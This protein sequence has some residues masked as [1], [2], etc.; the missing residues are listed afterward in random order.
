M[1]HSVC[2]PADAY[3]WKM[4]R[5]ECRGNTHVLNAG[6]KYVHERCVAPASG[7]INVDTTFEQRNEHVEMPLLRACFSEFEI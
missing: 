1:T 7:G 3:M 4:L 2:P 6:R 5:F